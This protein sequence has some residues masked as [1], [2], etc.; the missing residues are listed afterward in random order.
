MRNF[1][2]SRW[3]NFSI[4]KDIR[5][6][7]KES[8]RTFWNKL[9][10]FASVFVVCCTLAL[11]GL[12]CA[13]VRVIVAFSLCGAL[14]ALFVAPIIY[15]A[16]KDGKFA[17]KSINK[18]EIIRLFDEEI[19]YDILIA[20]EYYKEREETGLDDKI[21]SF[22]KIEE[23][24]YFEKVVCNMKFVLAKASV[25]GSEGIA[26]ERLLNVREIIRIIKDDLDGELSQEIL[27]ISK[28]ILERNYN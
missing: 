8:N 1:N 28:D 21:K 7:K 20:Y 2:P 16:I 4:Y 18:H 13:K 17:V 23:K 24:Y 10:L 12:L 19:I 9:Q 25:I 6:I 5:R 15:Y 27:T 3:Q 14:L 11:E 22:Y 26:M